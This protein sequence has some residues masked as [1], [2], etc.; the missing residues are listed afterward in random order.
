MLNPLVAY[1]K[2]TEQKS[3]TTNH[4]CCKTIVNP[5]AKQN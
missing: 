1:K 4:G 5:I 3:H 2:T